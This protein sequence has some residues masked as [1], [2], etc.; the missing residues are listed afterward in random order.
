MRLR[1][2]GDTGLEIS[3]II[4]GGGAVGG[5]L[6][7]ADDNTRRR[8]IRMALDAGINWIDT[9]ASYGSGASETAIGWLMKELP[10]SDRPYISTKTAFD[11]TVGDYVGQAERALTA[12]LER[13][14][15]DSVDLYQV[16][17]RVAGSADAFPN[18]ITPDDLLRENGIADA[19]H[20]LVDRG[21]TRHIGFTSTGEAEALHEVI[22]SGRFEC[23][24]VYYNLLN[25]SAGRDMKPNWSAYDQKNIISA[26]AANGVGVMVIRVLAAG[27]IATDVRTGKE[28]GVVLEGDVESD[29]QRMRSVLPLLKPEY[30]ARAQVAVRY[31]LRNPGVSGIEVGIAELD[32]LELA[33]GA[34]EM[35]PLPD[36]LLDQLDALADDNFGIG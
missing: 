20:S 10:E 28:G 29:V 18:A 16:H 5:I 11:R 35:G 19:M 24:Q 36:D 25:P 33:I 3:E 30:G 22:G 13:L 34:A 14:Q 7:D 4:F 23:A 12:S 9:A 1:K 8:A 27:V 32:H 15:M 6:I 2:L 31:A 26:C 21:L 17:N